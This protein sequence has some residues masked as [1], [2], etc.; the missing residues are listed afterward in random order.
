ML[1]YY[2]IPPLRLGPLTVHPF[3]VLVAT[4][5]LLGSWLATKRS[6]ELSLDETVTE[7]AAGWAVIPGFIVAHLYSALAYFPER[8]AENPLYILKVWDGISS[9]GGFLGGTLGVVYFLRTRGKANPWAYADS[10]AYGF[11]FAWIFGRLGC[12]VAFDHP[13][14]LTDFALAMRYPGDEE[15]K[16]GVRHNLGFYESLWAM[17]MSLFFFLQRK[18]PHFAGWYVGMF[19]LLYTPFRFSLDFLRAVDKRYLTFTP[20]QYAAIALFGVTLWVFIKRAQTPV[21]VPVQ[22]P[23]PGAQSRVEDKRKKA[24]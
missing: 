23:G 3:G 10:I 8:V 17:A 20:G 7:Q 18:R 21:I 5:V 14:S 4:A 24:R 2:E 15:L 19:G 22:D 13:G 1:P 6:R 12:T 11:T 16:A 9:F